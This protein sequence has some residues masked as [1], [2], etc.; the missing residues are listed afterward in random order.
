MNSDIVVSYIHLTLL[1]CRWNKQM[2]ACWYGVDNKLRL[3]KLLLLH[4][5]THLPSPL[6][7][8]SFVFFYLFLVDYVFLCVFRKLWQWSHKSIRS[9]LQFIVALSQLGIEHSLAVVSDKNGEDK[10]TFFSGLTRG[11][12]FQNVYL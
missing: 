6:R 4:N 5:L 7:S 3:I 1:N 9:I 11:L 8:N 2:L 10:H 12:S